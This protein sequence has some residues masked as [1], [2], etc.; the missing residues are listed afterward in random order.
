M[1]TACLLCQEK[2]SVSAEDLSLLQAISPVIGGRKEILPPPTLCPDCRQQRRLA[3]RNER[4]LYARKCDLTGKQI[5]SSYSPDKPYIVYDQA[6]WWSD[7]WDALSFGREFDFALPFF[8]QFAALQREVP[9]VS[10]VNTNSE[11]SVY[12]NYTANNKNCYLI[13]SNSYGHNEDCFYGTCLS[14]SVSCVDSINI[15][16]CQLCFDCIDCTDCYS[17]LSCRDCTECQESF[18][19]SDCRRCKNCIG[20]KGLR[21]KQYCVQNKQHTKEEYMKILE[22]SKTDTHAGY[23]GIRRFFDSFDRSTPQLFSRQ[24]S[25]EQCT[26][27]YLQNS[28]DCEQCFDTNGSEHC[29]YMQYSVSDDFNCCDA[30]YLVD[31]TNCYENLSLVQCSDCHFTN[32]TWWGVHGVL[33]SELCFNA[34][35]DCFGCIGL[36]GKQYCILNKQ[37]TKEEYEA[38]VPKII[39]HMKRTKEWGEFFPMFL[40]PFGYNETIAHEFFPLSEGEAKKRKWNWHPEEEERDQYLGPEYKI[41]DAI[42]DVPEDITKQILTC[43]V[44]N[45]PYKIIPQELKF[46]RQMNI[47]V[48][49][50]CPDQRHRE[51]MALRN[52][53]KL[54]NRE[55]AKC[56]SPIATSYA[57][58]RPEIVYCERCYLEAVY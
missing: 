41:P 15:F 27:D 30:S 5:I 54:W 31:S 25:C 48:P 49:R 36:R 3:F 1:N 43:A 44:T 51:R 8:K 37:Y 9:R 46:Y 39:E 57:P 50:K 26:G 19:L 16:N 55:C 29:R 47:P 17:L 12:T 40:S 58:D 52:P 38:L 23:E 28:R 53:R 35:R 32:L 6:E 18:F 4:R 42:A 20:C 56:R 10:V 33:Y 2:F 14:K 22:Q 45:K 11:N 7:A 24:K 34:T 21:D 13:F